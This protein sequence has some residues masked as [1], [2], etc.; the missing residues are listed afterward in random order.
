[1]INIIISCMWL[2][3]AG[4]VAFVSDTAFC[5]VCHRCYS[6]NGCTGVQQPHLPLCVGIPSAADL[7]PV[8]C[9]GLGFRQ[10]VCWRVRS[11]FQGHIMCWRPHM[12]DMVGDVYITIS[13]T[14]WFPIPWRFFTS[15]EAWK[16][17]FVFSGSEY[18]N[19]M[20]ALLSSVTLLK[21]GVLFQ[22]RVCY[23]SM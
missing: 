15:P 4:C 17:P 5:G 16:R 20:Q 22:E 3:G 11:C 19:S 7:P 2:W 8:H 13:C 23:V 12:H 10:A 18:A 9:G 1:M 21:G 14:G 6:P